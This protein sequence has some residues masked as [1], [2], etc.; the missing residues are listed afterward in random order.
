MPATIATAPRTADT[1]DSARVMHDGARDRAPSPRDHRPLLRR[2]ARALVGVLLAGQALFVAYLLA[3]YGRTALRGDVAAWARLSAK[4]WVP[5]DTGGN[6][7]MA[8]HVAVALVVLVAGALQLL[9]MVRRRAPRLHRWSGRVYLTSCI[10]GAVTGLA[11][12]WGRGTVGDDAQH[13]A[14]SINALLLLG[15]ATLAWRTAR[16]RRVDAHRAWALRTWF[17]AGGV[18]YF[19]I[20]LALWLLVHR[21]PV[22]FDPETFSGPFLT[23][24]AFTVYVFGPL[25]LLETV[26][27]AER[28]GRGAVHL[29]ASALLV[30]TSV[31]CAAG[32]VAAVLVLWLPNLA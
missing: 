5:G 9:P 19:R 1:A 15:C 25:T 32:A 20:M 31:T 3:S 27:A 17:V 8:T 12:V 11:L 30:V 10:V 6:A 14:I 28:S 26:R 13:V 22:G 29:A 7:A 24:L 21:A 4:G 18:F 2:C 16:A 23:T